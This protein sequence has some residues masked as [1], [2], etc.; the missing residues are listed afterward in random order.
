MVLSGS[1]IFQHRR[2]YP[3]SFPRI[4]FILPGLYRILSVRMVFLHGLDRYHR[5]LLG[6]TGFHGVYWILP[7][8]TGFYW[9][10]LGFTRF[11][12]VL[13]SFTGFYL[14]LLSFTKFSLK[15]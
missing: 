5:L 1:I 12:W 7:G 9:V 13:P 6:F 11:Y 15:P 3:P 8:F 14:V 10:A 2:C 4:D